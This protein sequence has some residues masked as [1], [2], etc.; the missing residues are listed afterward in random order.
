MEQLLVALKALDATVKQ[1]GFLETE[2]I[3]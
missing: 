1:Q 2:L 3:R